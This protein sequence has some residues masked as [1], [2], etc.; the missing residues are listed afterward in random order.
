MGTFSGADGAQLHYDDVGSS[1]SAPVIVL[2]GGPGREPD[3]LGDLAGLS[4]QY[5]LVIPHLRG[6][7]CSPSPMDTALGSFWRQAED[8]DRLHTALAPQPHVVIGHSAGTRLAVSYAVRFPDR[9]KSLILITPSTSYLIP[10]PPES[11]QPPRHRRGGDVFHRAWD[12]LIAGTDVSDDRAYNAWQ[13]A[14][15]PAGYAKWGPREQEHAGKGVWSLEAAQAFLAAQTPEDLA[16]RVAGIAVPT[17]VIAGAHDALAEFDSVRAFTELFARG[18]LV[19]IDDCGH[20]PW[21]EQPEVFRSAV[22]P[23]LRHHGTG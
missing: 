6:I 7:G 1:T 11:E 19:A 2:A 3:Y 14:T 22:D 8:I 5:R 13:L 12:R 23:F 17:L 18:Q 9:V 4:Q 21:I 10:D 16:D 20:Y 15:A